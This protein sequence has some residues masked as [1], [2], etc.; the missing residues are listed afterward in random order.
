MWPGQLENILFGK[1]SSSDSTKSNVSCNERGPLVD[2][3]QDN[4]CHINIETPTDG[5]RPAAFSRSPFFYISGFDNKDEGGKK[6]TDGVQRWLTDGQWWRWGPPLAVVIKLRNCRD[7]ESVCLRVKA[8]G[9]T[10]RRRQPYR[11]CQKWSERLLLPSAAGFRR[12]LLLIHGCHH[13][14]EESI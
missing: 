6:K 12:E 4:R 1:T 11:R 7:N 2:E 13:E 3:H 10:Q 5:R 9:D 14:P 8:L